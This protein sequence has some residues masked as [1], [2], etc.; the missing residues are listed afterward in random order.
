MDLIPCAASEEGECSFP[1]AVIV[2]GGLRPHVVDER[3]IR[4]VLHFCVCIGSDRW[5]VRFA[6]GAAACEY[7]EVKEG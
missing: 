7:G 1:R 4:F 6:L 5:F 2:A 3:A